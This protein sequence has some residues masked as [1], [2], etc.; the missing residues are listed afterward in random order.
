MFM[1][2]CNIN[3]IIINII[4][5]INFEDI[6]K[7]KTK[8]RWHQNSLKNISFTNPARKW[9]LWNTVCFSQFWLAAY[10]IQFNKFSLFACFFQQAKI[11]FS[12]PNSLV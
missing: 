3:Y 5:I 2:Y 7:I 9:L 1:V 8:E 12:L 10:N 6:D 11:H 4:I